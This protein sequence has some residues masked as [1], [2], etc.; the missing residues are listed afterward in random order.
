[1]KK[2]L[3][4]I[5]GLILLLSGCNNDIQNSNASQETITANTVSVLSGELKTKYIENDINYMEIEKDDKVY[6]LNSEDVE[7]FE[8]FVDGQIITLEHDENNVVTDILS[9]ED[10]EI[11]EDTQN[12]ETVDESNK[13]ISFQENIDSFQENID[14]NNL[15]EYYLV[16]VS[17]FTNGEVESVVVYTD[18]EKDSNG[19]FM[20][21]DGHVFKVVANSNNGG[22]ILFDER[23]QLGSLNVNVYMNGD[24]LNVSILDYGTAHIRHR[25]FEKDGNSFIENIYFNGN[26]NI[27]MIGS[28]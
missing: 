1:M 21:D 17:D 9:V 6:K 24:K 5:F 8:L 27:N 16:D 2:T 4:L 28:I 10:P 7:D 11:K 14:I 25:V 18:A 12:D 23:I 22:Y 19:E 13:V 26:E 3:I 20:W 15:T